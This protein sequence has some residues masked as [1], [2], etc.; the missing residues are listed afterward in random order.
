M[1]LWFAR[2]FAF[3]GE[4]LAKFIN[5]APLLPEGQLIFLQWQARPLANRAT[6]ILGWQATPFKQGLIQTIQHL[7]R[8]GILP[9]DKKILKNEI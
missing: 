4:G 3:L 5:K 9:S 2:V 6:Q 1:P 8:S 7:Q